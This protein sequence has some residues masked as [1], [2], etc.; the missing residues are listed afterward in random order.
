MQGVFIDGQR[1]SSKKA[2]T[3]MLGEDPARVRFE[4]TSIFGD[5]YDGT[6][7]Q[8]SPS[9]GGVMFVGPDPYTARRFYGVAERRPD[10]TFRVR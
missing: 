9:H 4:S 3:A 10:G 6:A 7:D 8:L 2:V 1:P 5:E